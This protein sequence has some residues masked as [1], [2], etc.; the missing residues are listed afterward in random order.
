MTVKE[1]SVK[2]G[3]S[4]KQIRRIIDDELLEHSRNGRNIIIPDDTEIII[5]KIEVQS[6]LWQIVAYKNN[7]H[8]VISR[9]LCPELSQLQVLTKFLYQ[10]GFIGEYS[11]YSTGDDFFEKVQL[12]D[13]GLKY[14]LDKNKAVKFYK[15]FEL[16]IIPNINIGL[17]IEINT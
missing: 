1:A 14:V 6:F 11:E 13:R 2:F 17:N 5:S 15:P 9:E 16:T 4:E 12:T 8:C 7:N 3:K 10:H